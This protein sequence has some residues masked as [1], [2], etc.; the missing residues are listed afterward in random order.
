M[1]MERIH[2]LLLLIEN[3]FNGLGA[4]PGFLEKGFICIKGRGFALLIFLF[5]L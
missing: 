5:F 3:I 4:D 2:G 1:I